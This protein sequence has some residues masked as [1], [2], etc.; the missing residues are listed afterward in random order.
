MYTQI[1]DLQVY[2]TT[3]RSGNNRQIAAADKP[4]YRPIIFYMPVLS[5]YTS[6]HQFDVQLIKLLLK[7]D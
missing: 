2:S 7:M 1:I 5:A 6:T 4:Y 3:K